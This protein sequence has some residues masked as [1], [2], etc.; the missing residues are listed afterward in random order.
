[1]KSV[2][3]FVVLSALLV[4]LAVQA[5]EKKSLPQIPAKDSPVRKT[6]A[7]YHLSM[8]MLLF[9]DYFM[10]EEQFQQAKE[11][12]FANSNIPTVVKGLQ[13]YGYKAAMPQ[14]AEE[15][16][17]KIYPQILAFLKQAGYFAVEIP[18]GG[19]NV[20]QCRKL[21]KEI[22]R[23]KL[24]VTAVGM[25][26]KD[27]EASLR[28]LIDNAHALGAK[29]LAGPIVL[30]FKQY[31]K[32]AIGDARVA[33]VK[34]RL[35]ELR[36][37]LRHVAEYAKSKDVKLAVEPLNRFELPG[38]NRLQEAIDFTRAVDHPNFGVMIDTCHE[39][40]EGEGPE[41][42]REQV[43]T[44]AAMKRLFHFHISAINRGRIDRSWIH[45][46]VFIAALKQ[47]N[48]QGN[49]SM[50]IFDATLPFSDV[51]HVN[52]RRFENPLEV[53]LSALLHS[54]GQL[55]LVDSALP[56]PTPASPE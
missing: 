11:Q 44:L 46:P 23:L 26:G 39:M 37:P 3:S 52:R 27:L 48:Y 36:E 10:T 22:E 9:P 38:L 18:V 12:Q 55:Y 21:K 15:Y 6:A 16:R 14:S 42:F 40:S 51:V 34:N 35:E 54:A 43:K 49:M 1:M 8:N 29:V 41:R 13:A 47:A 17:Q 32:N 24:G 45:W 19:G 53:A 5:G 25:A 31:P 33:W 4:P 56:A 30:P 2:G 7:R 20:E 50:E 28:P